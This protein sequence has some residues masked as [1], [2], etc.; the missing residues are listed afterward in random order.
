M[1]VDYILS[2]VEHYGPFIIFICLF[3]G[4]VGIP[5]PEE[6]LV[7]IIGILIHQHTL[8]AIPSI[9]C[10]FFGVL[11][12]FLFSYTIGRY[13]GTPF[14][15]K[16]TRFLRLNDFKVRAFQEKYEANYKRALLTGLYIPGARQINPYLAGISQIAFMPYLIV[17]LIG[18][19]IWVV[20]FMTIGFVT[21]N[22]VTIK[23]EFLP[24]IGIC[25]G[26]I[27]ILYFVIKRKY[28]KKS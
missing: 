10:A 13:A 14:L 24:L 6:T 27:F 16:I 4:V 22:I 17:S 26:I 1:S 7:V 19:T 5:A 20:P 11:C 25:I 12:G 21:A 15:Y 23:Y 18:T 8:P 28:R 9:L 2:L 3:F